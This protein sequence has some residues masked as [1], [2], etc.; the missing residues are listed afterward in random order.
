MEWGPNNMKTINMHKS[1]STLRELKKVRTQ[2]EHSRKSI[3]RIKILLD[4]LDNKVDFD[5]KPNK[6]FGHR[7]EGM[8]RTLDLWYTHI[9]D[10]IQKES[11]NFEN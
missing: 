3:N 1:N 5:D 10:L 8:L 4:K 9:N 7:G 11:S 6:I 2:M